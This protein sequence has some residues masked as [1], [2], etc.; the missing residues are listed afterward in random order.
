M[1]NSEYVAKVSANDFPVPCILKKR[2]FQPGHGT[3]FADAKKRKL[4]SGIQKLPPNYFSE[5]FNT[6]YSNPVSYPQPN[7]KSPNIFNPSNQFT[8]RH[9]EHKIPQDHRQKFKAKSIPK[10]LYK[11]DFILKN[12]EKPLTCPQEFPLSTP[13]P[14]KFKKKS[15]NSENFPTSTEVFKA[16][17]MPNF[18]NP[19]KPQHFFTPTKSTPKNLYKCTFRNMSS[20]KPD[21]HNL[22]SSPHNNHGT[23][24]YAYNSPMDSD[25][26]TFNKRQEFYTNSKNFRDF[27]PTKPMNIEL[28]TF[29]RAQEREIFEERLRENERWKEAVIRAENE[30]KIKR[31][32]EQIQNIRRQTE[33]KARPMPNYKS[34]AFDM[35]KGDAMEECTDHTMSTQDMMDLE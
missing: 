24:N 7:T 3:I 16:R 30:E 14:H 21:N 35:Y 31:D 5:S 2:H 12:S 22:L 19:F 27:E 18:S 25:L 4:E 9:A 10:S 1:N 23:P 15:C 13:S 11:P 17:P 8:D 28:H 32:L 20:E 26:N 34:K 6:I 33:F 29:K